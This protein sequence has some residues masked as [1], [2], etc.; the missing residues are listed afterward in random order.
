MDG[1]L[2]TFCEGLQDV[3]SGNYYSS[4]IKNSTGVFV[5]YN[6]K[7][8]LAAYAEILQA[9]WIDVLLPENYPAPGATI[10]NAGLFDCGA[11]QADCQVQITAF[12]WMYQVCSEFGKST[13]PGSAPSACAC[14]CAYTKTGAFQVTN[15]SR[16]TSLLPKVESIDSWVQDCITSFGESVADGPNLAPINKK[17]GGWDMSPSNVFFTSG[18]LDPWR[19]VS[20]YSI[21]S[22]SP[23]RPSTTDV[24]ASGKTEGTTFFG[25]L[26]EGAY[27][28]A[29]LGNVVRQNK[30]TS[31]D[32]TDPPAASLTT[33]ETNANTAHTLF[34]D[35]LNT[36]LPAFEKHS[37]SKALTI[38]SSDVANGG[39]T[40]TKKKNGAA[41]NVVSVRGVFWSVFVSLV[42]YS[43][44]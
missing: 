40:G 14:A 24:P 2:G 33:I 8:A 4:S 38:S 26:I 41:G 37:V 18:E 15:S 32:P 13:L 30:T 29:D 27:H 28:C 42:V 17:Y 44:L 43:V 23:D 12:A 35:A 11:S 9:I 5:D 20:L 39:T 16:P 19:G 25:Y 21:E 22:D 31:L 1:Y 10:T 7:V 3:A 36:W 6:F 34:I